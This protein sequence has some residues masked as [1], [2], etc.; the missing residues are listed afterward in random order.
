[1]RILN[2]MR[3][4]CPDLPRSLAGVLAGTVALLGIVAMLGAILKHT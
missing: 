2:A 4:Q 1:M 3:K